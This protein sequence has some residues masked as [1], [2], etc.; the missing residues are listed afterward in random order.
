MFYVGVDVPMQR[1]PVANWVLIGVTVI[2]TLFAWGSESKALDEARQLAATLDNAKGL[3]PEQ[4]AELETKINKVVERVL[5]GAL[6]PRHFR[7]PQLITHAFI[8]GDFWHLLGNMIFLF[9]FGNAINAKLGH[10]Q[11]LVCYFFFAAFA[12]FGWII[13]GDGMPMV[14]ASGAIMG[15]A[16]MFFV[17]YPFNELAIHSPDTYFWS[18]DAWRM[19]SWVFVLIYMVLD[20]LG[21]LQKG[22]GIAYAAYLAG[23]I[24]GMTLAFGLV[25]TGWVAS[26]RGEQNLLE[27]WG[28]VEEAPPP[29]KRRRKPKPPPPIVEI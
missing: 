4:E 2:A 21:T 11:F 27:A 13:L 3:T 26:D 29:R 28:W 7:L 10:W 19:P 5:G 17:L 23:E 20:L 6:Q 25:K 9:A 1:Y 18:G 24:G 16:G 12:G 15:I 22:A 8:H 14:G